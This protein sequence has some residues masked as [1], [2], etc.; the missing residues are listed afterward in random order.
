MRTNL[1]TSILAELADIESRIAKLER[2]KRYSQSSITD[3]QMRVIT[4]GGLTRTEFGKLSNDY[5]ATG[6]DVYGMTVFRDNGNPLFSVSDLG[7]YRPFQLIPV[8]GQSISNVNYYGPL[9][10]DATTGYL[11]YQTMLFDCT[12]SHMAIDIFANLIGGTGTL[13]L[14]LVAGLSPD[15]SV[16]I[17]EETGITTDESHHIDTIDLTSFADL[18][19]ES[20]IGDRLWI[21][22]QAKVSDSATS[23]NIFHW[24]DPYNFVSQA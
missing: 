4:S 16:T 23:W 20:V 15:V 9:L 10:A 18:G 22:L 21:E 12:A 6:S 8:A 11:T 3:G 7:L 2:S 17:F 24:R 13:G 1:P 14:R 19:N 5:H